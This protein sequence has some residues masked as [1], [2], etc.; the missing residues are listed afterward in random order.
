MKR[1]E[2]YIKSFLKSLRKKVDDSS[3][4]ALSTYEQISPYIVTDISTTIFSNM[5]Q[6]Y[7]EFEFSQIIS[8]E[9]SN[10]LTEKYY[11]FHL[12]EKKL[13]DLILGLFYV[14]R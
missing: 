8:P 1:Q 10:I 2:D 7:S 14:P 6:R 9:G 12:D 13:D 5:L 3:S 4:F 11:E